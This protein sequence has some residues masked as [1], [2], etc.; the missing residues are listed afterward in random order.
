MPKDMTAHLA[1]LE[2]WAE[3][4]LQATDAP[5]SNKK[6]RRMKSKVFPV[7]VLS[8]KI[9]ERFPLAKT[10]SDATESKLLHVQT[11][12]RKK[13]VPKDP[14]NCAMAQACK[15]E[16]KATEAW[17]GKTRA[18]VLHGT[19]L[20]RFAVP[21]S[22]YREQTS[23]DRHADFAGGTYRLSRVAPTQL[24]SHSLG[25]RRGA[26][27]AP[28]PRR[29]KKTKPKNHLPMHYTARVRGV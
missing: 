22:V 2:T 17:I 23:F 6:E 5:T 9:R 16:W 25:G 1:A 3:A 19:H 12:D 7:D 10:V 27:D 21:A 18:Y 29:K 28:T 14:F 4:A 11:R 13:A 20:L 26:K 8:P 15:R 24:S